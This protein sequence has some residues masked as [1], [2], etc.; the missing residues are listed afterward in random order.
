MSVQLNQPNNFE[1][2][3]FA[4]SLLSVDLGNANETVMR[5]YD[6]NGS[7]L[8]DGLPQAL[9]G[10][11]KIAVLGWS[12][13][14]PAQAQNIRDSLNSAGLGDTTQVVVGLRDGSKSRDDAEKAGFSLK[15]STLDTVEGAID[16]ADLSLMLISDAAMAKHGQDFVG[17]AKPGSVIGLSHGFWLGHLGNTGETPRSDVGIIGVCPK[18]MGPSVRKL[19]KQ[20]SGINTSFAV[21]QGGQRETDLALGWSR[22]LGAPYTFQTTLENE[23]RSDIFGERAVL[24]GGVHGIVEAMYKDRV[25]VGSATDIRGV[26]AYLHVVESLV[27]PIS[28]TISEK[29]LTGLYDSI[30]EDEKPS[31]RQAY[32]AAYGPLRELTEKI[33]ADVS[34][35]REIAEVIADNERDYPM[36]EIGDTPMWQVGAEV[37]R[38]RLTV[39]KVEID[40][41]VAGVYAAAMMAQV[42]VLMSKGHHM[43]EIVNESII[44][45][46][47]S[48]NPYMKKA[49][50]AYMVDNCSVTAR[51]GSRKWAPQYEA[52][53]AQAV[54]P[55]INGANNEAFDDFENH[56]VHSV[57]NELAK[58]RP[59]VAIAL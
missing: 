17:L 55:N 42:D 28:S 54:L 13:Q 4:D 10:V 1:S 8:Y 7:R 33:Y 3:I 34:S 35:G 50:V 43:S 5:G 21:N 47:D 38:N 58:M 46:V 49:G 26:P 2:R 25:G 23:W 59:P 39:D 24:L 15:N 40:T 32:R 52:V 31:F 41:K 11:A 37:R 9:D 44:E 36:F 6:E 30:P 48:L 57:L 22:M 56:P 29:G 20:D 19:Y 51:R 16:D 14:G 18:G 12:S 27:G 53:M 45:A